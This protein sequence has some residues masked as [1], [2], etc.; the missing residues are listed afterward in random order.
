LAGKPSATFWTGT[1]F[2]QLVAEKPAAKFG[3]GNPFG[4]GSPLN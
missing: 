3:V 1:P 2:F 4:L